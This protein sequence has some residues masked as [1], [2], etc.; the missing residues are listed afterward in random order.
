M[1]DVAVMGGGVPFASKAG[2]AGTMGEGI[3]DSV[4]LRVH[5]DTNRLDQNDYELTVLPLCG[6]IDDDIR[7][8]P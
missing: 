3:A 5:S 1:I 2:V 8:V 7:M 4:G 6:A